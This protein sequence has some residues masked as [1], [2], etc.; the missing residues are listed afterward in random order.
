MIAGKSNPITAKCAQPHQ[1][2]Y[3]QVPQGYFGQKQPNYTQQPPR[4]TIRRMRRGV[5]AAVAEAN[6]INLRRS[7]QRGEG[8]E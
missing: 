1:G 7:V 6:G 2:Y 8:S 4:V 5:R 3:R